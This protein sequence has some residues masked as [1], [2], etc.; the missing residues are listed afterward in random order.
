MQI[1]GVG[2]VN[3]RIYSRKQHILEKDLI[4]DLFGYVKRLLSLRQ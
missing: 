3:K 2:Q 4:G 1:L